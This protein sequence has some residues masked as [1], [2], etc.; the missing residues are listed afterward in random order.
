MKDRLIHGLTNSLSS[1]IAY[2]PLCLLFYYM[3]KDMSVLVNIWIAVFFILGC[4][5][6]KDEKYKENND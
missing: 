1:V 6:N 4:C 3:F 2:G 5:N